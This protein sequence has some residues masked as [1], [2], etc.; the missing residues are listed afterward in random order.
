ME[1]PHLGKHCSEKTCR[2]LD[3]LPMKCD[4]CSEIFCTDHLQYD[5]H[6]CNSSYKKNI[7]V[8]VCPLCN[9]PI[10]VPRGTVPDLAV[11]EHIENNCQVRSK[12]AV[13]SNRCNKTKC[14]K[15]EL[16]P[17][18]CDSCKLNFC[19]THR[20][21]TDH[22][23]QGPQ[24]TSRAAAA[25][26]ARAGQSVGS[27]GQSKISGFFSGPFRQ[28]QPASSASRPSQ[29]RAAPS[30]AAAA[31]LNRQA[32]RGSTPGRPLVARAEN[33]GMSEDEALAAA[34]AASLTSPGQAEAEDE[35]RQLALALQESERQAA[36]RRG[37]TA[38]GP[39][40]D[41]DKSCSVQ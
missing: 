15:K 4:A 22:D 14:K 32:G 18:L 35:D 10:P 20:H 29:P 21:P 5:D 16:V 31:A 17:I 1:L 39:P 2:Q 3:F 30:S 6:R 25:A 13:F 40:G 26:T 7:Q 38:G 9:Q 37:Q 23:C 24:T 36:A 33:G 12:K 8:P 19:L 11:S 27:S 34:L 41:G 28:P